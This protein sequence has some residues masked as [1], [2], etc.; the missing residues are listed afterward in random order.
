[1]SHVTQVTLKRSLLF[2]ANVVVFDGKYFYVYMPSQFNSEGLPK[3]LVNQWW[4]ESIYKLDNYTEQVNAVCK[5][6]FLP[7]AALL[8]EGKSNQVKLY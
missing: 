3:M 1:M 6:F 4:T 7:L 2:G 8:I 5:E